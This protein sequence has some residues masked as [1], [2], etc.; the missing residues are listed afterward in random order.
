MTTE[1]D[2]QDCY[3]CG[4]EATQ[5]D[6]VPPANLFGKPRP[7][8]LI[9]VPICA[10]CH[11]GTSEDD[12]LFRTTLITQQD[13]GDPR[14]AAV[15]KTTQRGLSRN[16]ARPFK[17]IVRLLPRVD[18]ATEAGI[19]VGQTQGAVFKRPPAQ[20]VIDRIVRG[21]YL[22]RFGTRLPDGYYVADFEMNPNLADLGAET[23]GAFQDSPLFETD[24]RVYQ[25][26]MVATPEDAAITT[27]ICR[28]YER[29]ELITWTL[30]DGFDEHAG[31]ASTR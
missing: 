20:K 15:W 17:G 5:K 26:R 27:F 18:V 4:G 11:S 24:D 16:E 2:N 13:P 31:T 19:I 1:S 6:H 22:H 25:Y 10:D 28:F 9:T 12:E 23:L 29:T 3:L 21:M 7:E 14:V 30:P 8:N